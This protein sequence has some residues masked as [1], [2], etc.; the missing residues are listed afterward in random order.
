VSEFVANS[1]GGGWHEQAAAVEHSGVVARWSDA[2]A[3]PVEYAEARAADVGVM[4]VAVGRCPRD[5]G[6]GVDRLAEV[7]WHGPVEER[8]PK[9][10]A[11]RGIAAMSS[12]AARSAIQEL[13]QELNQCMAGTGS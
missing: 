4:E 2:P 5:G 8:L 1:G 11:V 12:S 10:D 3:F 6:V 13:E 9:S 7:T